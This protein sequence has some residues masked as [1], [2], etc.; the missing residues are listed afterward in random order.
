MTSDMMLDI[1]YFR[2]YRRVLNIVLVL[3][4][5]RLNIT[6]KLFST[7]CLVRCQM[8]PPDEENLMYFPSTRSM[9]PTGQ[10]FI[11]FLNPT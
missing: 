8:P 4:K 2:S 11:K 5:L 9:L 1:L 10:I 3:L 6:V 7:T